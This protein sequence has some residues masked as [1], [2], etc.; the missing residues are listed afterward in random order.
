M[1]YIVVDN[2]IKIVFL[3]KEINCA[4]LVFTVFFRYSLVVQLFFVCR[5]FWLLSSSLTYFGTSNMVPV[6]SH[7]IVLYNL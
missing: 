7:V 5:V 6:S 2:W 3:I 1:I 4:N